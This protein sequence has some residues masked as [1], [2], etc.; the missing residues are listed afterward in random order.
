VLLGAGIVAQGGKDAL[1]RLVEIGKIAGTEPHSDGELQMVPTPSGNKLYTALTVWRDRT[2]TWLFA[3]DAGGTQGWKAINGQLTPA[4][5]NAT[6]GTSPVVAGGLLYVYNPSGGLE[7][8]DPRTGTE[9]ARLAC[10]GGHWNSPIVADERI[11]LPE[12][13]AND[14][15]NTGVLNIWSVAR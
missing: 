8:Y 15:S 12:G 14:H 6:G 7:V 5:K 3:A 1:I 13:N 9:L 10:G 11:A 2:T 4:W